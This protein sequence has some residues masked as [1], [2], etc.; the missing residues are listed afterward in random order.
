MVRDTVFGAATPSAEILFERAGVRD[1]D[2]VR[3]LRCEAKR[4]RLPPARSRLLSSRAV[5]RRTGIRTLG[6]EG[7][8]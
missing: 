3:H 8:R 5:A 1:C 6:S 7:S 4:Q 2:A